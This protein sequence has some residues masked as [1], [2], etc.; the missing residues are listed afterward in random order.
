MENATWIFSI[1]LARVLLQKPPIIQILDIGGF[2]M[3]II[4]KPIKSELTANFACKMSKLWIERLNVP[5]HN[6]DKSLF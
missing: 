3:L 5:S 6:I 4:A 1:A 2:E